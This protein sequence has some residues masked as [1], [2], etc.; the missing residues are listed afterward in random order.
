MLLEGRGLSKP[1]IVG[2]LIGFRSVRTF[3]ESAGSR[4]RTFI[5]KTGFFRDQVLI[6]GVLLEGKEEHQKGIGSL[7][8]TWIGTGPG[9]LSPCIRVR[10]WLN[11]LEEL[12]VAAREIHSSVSKGDQVFVVLEPLPTK[13]DS[14]LPS[15]R[16][17][18]TSDEICIRSMRLYTQAGGPW[19][20]DGPQIQEGREIMLS[21]YG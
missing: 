11:S 12:Q 3:D 17:L 5:A 2:Q 21:P 8:I 4:L 1:R 13:E 6:E 7:A 20:A 10:L 19:P 18:G 9:R 15:F 16:E 14:W